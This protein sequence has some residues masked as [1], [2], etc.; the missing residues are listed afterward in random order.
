M[1]ASTSNKISKCCS[2]L[3]LDVNLYFFFVIIYYF[4]YVCFSRLID[5]NRLFFVFE[6]FFLF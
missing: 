6:F 5:W 4:T 3:G 1:A 2:P